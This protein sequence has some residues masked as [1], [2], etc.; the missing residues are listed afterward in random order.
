MRGRHGFPP[1]HVAVGKNGFGL[2]LVVIGPCRPLPVVFAV[3]LIVAAARGARDVR[4]KDS[5]RQRSKN[6]SA[7]QEVQVYM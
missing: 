5:G 4:V 3:V 6:M 7:A 1:V 2:L